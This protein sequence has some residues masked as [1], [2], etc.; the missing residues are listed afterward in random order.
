MRSFRWPAHGSLGAVALLL[1]LTAPVARAQ[2]ANSATAQALFD[3][4]KQL[5]AAGKPSEACPKF[6][7]SQ[8]LDPGL[9]TLLNLAACYETAGQLAS[10]WSTFLEADSAASAAGSAEGM[11]VARERSAALAPKLSKLVITVSATPPDGLEIKRDDQIVGRPQWGVPI[12]ADPG[13]HRVLVSAPGR[14]PWQAEVTLT[15]PGSQVE[16]K[17][18][19]LAVAPVA[20][21]SASAPAPVVPS[22]GGL[23][24]QRYIAIGSG[25][26]GVAGVVVG[27]VFGLRAKSKHDSAEDHCDGSACR[28]QTGVEL[29]T[30]ARSAGNVSTVGFIVGGVGLAGAA[31]LWFTAAP[32]SPEAPRAALELGPG[33]LAVHGTF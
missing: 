20:A 15:E 26:L 21:P 2:S 22:R 1:L 17:V 4:A 32:E 18:P 19:E 11:R 10:A 28:D 3:D 6:A 30:Q 16:V 14:T 12:P 27:S 24:T 29:R 33:R 23:G 31:V 5:M 9:G 7:E 8:R 25:V 13:K